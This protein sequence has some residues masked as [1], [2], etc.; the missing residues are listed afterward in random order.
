MFEKQMFKAMKFIANNVFECSGVIFG[1]Y[2][3]DLIIHDENAVK[4]HSRGS[5]T[6][7]QY[8]DPDFHRDT[9]DR[10]LIPK[11]IDC[12]FQSE[13]LMEA[14]LTKMKDDGYMVLGAISMD[15][16]SS[17]YENLPED[18]HFKRVRMVPKMPSFMRPLFGHDLD[19]NVDILYSENA[20][21]SPPFNSVDFT[22]NTLIMK[23]PESF[24]LSPTYLEM[25]KIHTQPILLRE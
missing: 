15:S 18:V 13:E 12:F 5:F 22:C 24:T 9:S 11:D 7:A 2:P 14:F 25:K 19:V 21:V 23:G 20:N 17:P 6:N 3:R 4:F 16:T 1:G 10:L 8:S